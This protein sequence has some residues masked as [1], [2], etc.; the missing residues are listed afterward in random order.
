MKRIRRLIAATDGDVDARALAAAAGRILRDTLA[1]MERRETAS[2]ASVMDVP[3][4]AVH[5]INT[6]SVFPPMAEM[7]AETGKA[8]TRV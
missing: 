4:T 8:R 2:F 7:I 3:I 1:A 6:E 5:S